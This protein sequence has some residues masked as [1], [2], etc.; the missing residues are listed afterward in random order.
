MPGGHTKGPA[1]RRRS[2]RLP[3]GSGSCQEFEAL[4]SPAAR[5]SAVLASQ[6]LFFISSRGFSTVKL[7]P[8]SFPQLQDGPR[9]PEPYLGGRD[10][11]GRSREAGGGLALMSL[12]RESSRRLRAWSQALFHRRDAF[13]AAVRRDCG[14]GGA[15]GARYADADTCCK[16]S[17]SAVPLACSPVVHFGLKTRRFGPAAMAGVRGCCKKLSSLTLLQPN[18]TWEGSGIHSGLLKAS[19]GLW[20]SK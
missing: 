18:C 17:S 16:L 2:P 5:G 4:L 3:K 10:A 9:E 13:Q 6:S 12:G 20:E 7:P 19:F 14:A 11:D 1:H 15:A 8:P